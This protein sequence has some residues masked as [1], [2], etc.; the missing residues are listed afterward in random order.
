MF[1]DV[2]GRGRV[3]HNAIIGNT[4]TNNALEA[5]LGI[6]TWDPRLGFRQKPIPSHCDP[7]LSI[8]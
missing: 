7:I 4:L 8:P 6:R 3:S 1:S 5:S 2:A